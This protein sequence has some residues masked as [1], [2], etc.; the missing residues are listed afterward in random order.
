LAGA[1][2]FCTFLCNNSI[3]LP[4]TGSHAEAAGA[5]QEASAIVEH[6]HSELR[7]GWRRRWIVSFFT[8]FRDGPARI[9]EPGTQSNVEPFS[10][11]RL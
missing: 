4:R 8:I 6:Y 10:A 3:T 9:V 11:V 7:D 1:G 2:H 5:F